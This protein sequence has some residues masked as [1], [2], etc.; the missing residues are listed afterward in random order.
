M[1][2]IAAM[3]S[4]IP[5]SVQALTS[6]EFHELAIFDAMLVTSLPQLVTQLFTSVL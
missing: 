1:S 5:S 2:D 6:G 4:Y 3:A